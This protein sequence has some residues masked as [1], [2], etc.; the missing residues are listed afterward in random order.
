[1]RNLSIILIAFCFMTSITSCS[2]DN[3]GPGGQSQINVKVLNG[4]SNV[5]DAE[6]KVLYNA[7]TYPGSSASY[8]ASSTADHKGNA[9]FKDLRRGDYYFYSAVETVDT[10]YEGGAYVRIRNSKG[11][12]H[13]VIDFGADD[14]FNSVTPPL[15]NP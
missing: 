10:I 5:P 12:T 1:M 2:K 11:E 6:V 15:E 14:P 3:A 4:N 7:R 8:S 13:I 9:V